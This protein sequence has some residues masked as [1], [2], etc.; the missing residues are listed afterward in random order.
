MIVAG[1]VTAVL[2]AIRDAAATAVASTPAGP[3]DVV[4]VVPGAVAWDACDCGQLSVTWSRM[5]LSNRFPTDVAGDDSLQL[6]P[7]AAAVLVLDVTVEVVRCAPVPQG[8]ATTVACSA[9]EAAARVTADD[10]VAVLQGVACALFD[11]ET[12]GT[13][14]AHQVRQQVAKGPQGG[15][16]GS[17]LGLLVGLRR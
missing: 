3:V 2:E 11:L 13:V 17:E 6:Q 15:C 4:C 1:A 12:A 10:A 16:V 5:Y 7:C 8:N 9:L 14:Y